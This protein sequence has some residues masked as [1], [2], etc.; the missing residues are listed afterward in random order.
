MMGTD[1]RWH[2]HQTH[3]CKTAELVDYYIKEM[4]SFKIQVTGKR[5]LGTALVV[6]F[7][8]SVDLG[9]SGLDSFSASFLWVLAE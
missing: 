5:V 1:E 2:K 4:Y 7:F 3:K 6:F 9:A 8:L